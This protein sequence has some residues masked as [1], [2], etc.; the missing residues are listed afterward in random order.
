LGYPVLG[1]YTA[2]QPRIGDAV[3]MVAVDR[4]IGDRF[5]RMENAEDPVP[6]LPPTRVNAQA[7]A[8]IFEAPGSAKNISTQKT[9]QSLNYAPLPGWTLEIG[10]EGFSARL[11]AP[12]EYEQEFGYMTAF[13]AAIDEARLD[14]T[15]AAQYTQN[16]L[17]HIGDSYICGF[18]GLLAKG[19]EPPVPQ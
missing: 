6:Y 19:Q 14:D 17:A 1:V 16:G 5:Y 15:V 18:I 13:K 4:L 3:M 11:G 2:A 7:F 10:K 9:V 12:Q 8:D